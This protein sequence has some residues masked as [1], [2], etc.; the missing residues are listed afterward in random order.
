VLAR[1]ELVGDGIDEM[2][3]ALAPVRA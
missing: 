2:L 1:N 3:L